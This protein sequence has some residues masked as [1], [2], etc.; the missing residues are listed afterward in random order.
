MSFQIPDPTAQANDPKAWVTTGTR[1]P[2]GSDLKTIEMLATIKALNIGVDITTVGPKY[3]NWLLLPDRTVTS[4]LSIA[5]FDIPWQ[6]DIFAK[7]LAAKSY[8]I[9]YWGPRLSTQTVYATIETLALGVHNAQVQGSIDA[10]T[11]GQL[12]GTTTQVVSAQ[13]AITQ[14]ATTT[15][16]SAPVPPKVITGGDSGVGT[17][18][19]PASGE[20]LS[21]PTSGI[22]GPLPIGQASGTGGGPGSLAPISLNFGGGAPVIDVGSGG[23]AAGALTGG[24]AESVSIKPWLWWV[25]A[26]VAL[27]VIVAAKKRHG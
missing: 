23:V 13:T 20:S 16:P 1:V 27:V 10:G 5:Q 2:G 14:A 7:Q 25:L 9:L 19:P 17:M 3:A 22:S 6:A 8:L 21:Y 4:D 11:P 12:I 26:A 18:L 24:T 15:Q